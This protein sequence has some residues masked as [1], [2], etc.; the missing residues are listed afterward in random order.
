MLHPVCCL[1]AM[2]V[3]MG[4][5]QKLFIENTTPPNPDLLQGSAKWLRKA[6]YLI[7]SK[8]AVELIKIFI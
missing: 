6:S 1:F 2:S 4:L 8:Q 3:G 7:T 5:R